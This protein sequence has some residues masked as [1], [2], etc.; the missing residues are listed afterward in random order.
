VSGW[1][2]VRERT[3]SQKHDRKGKKVAMGKDDERGDEESRL[4]EIVNS[5]LVNWQA[6][7]AA[8]AIQRCVWKRVGATQCTR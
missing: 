1:V 3:P 4:G 5:Q 6:Q 2:R 8:C 7:A